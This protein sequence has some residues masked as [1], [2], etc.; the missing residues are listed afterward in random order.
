MDKN[1]PTH[2]MEEHVLNVKII[3]KTC[4]FDSK[5]GSRTTCFA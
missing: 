1:I 3:K 2:L 5:N 4:R